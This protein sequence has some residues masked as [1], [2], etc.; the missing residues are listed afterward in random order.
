MIKR[1]NEQ[2]R[3]KKRFSVYS[4]VVSAVVFLI[5]G[6]LFWMQIVQGD[7]YLQKA[8]QQQLR[9]ITIKAPRGDILDRYGRPLVTNKTGY[10]LQIQ[11]TTLSN[12]EFNAVIL[13]LYD[14]LAEQGEKVLETLPVSQPPFAFTFGAGEPDAQKVSEQER[15]W[16]KANPLRYDETLSADEVMEKLR[17]RYKISADYTPEQMRRI[18]GV[19]YEMELRGFSVSTPFTIASDVSMNLV[20]KLKEE[21]AD[22]SCVNVMSEYVRQFDQGSLAAHI[23]GRVGIISGDE[24]DKYQHDGYKK[25]D[26][27][28]KQGIEKELEKYLRGKDGI[29]SMV[30][31]SEG[32]EMQPEAGEAPV[33]GDYVV[34]TIDSGLQDAVE[35]A[36]GQT[37]ENIRSR[38]GDPGAKSGG[39]AYCGAAVVLDVNSGAVLATATWPTYDPAKFREAYASMLSDPNKPMWNRALSGTYPPGSTFKMLTSIAA[40]EAGVI[41]PDTVIQDKGIYRFYSDYQPACWIWNKSHTTHGNQT[42]TAALV[43]SCNYFYYEVG[44]LMGIDTLNEYAKKFGF[45]EYTGIELSGEESQGRLAGPAD[46]QKY[47]GGQWRGGDTLQAAIG[48]SE[49]LFTPLQLANYVAT[50]ANG[51]TRY[52]PYLVKTVRAAGNG[53]C[54]LESTPEVIEEIQIKPETLNAIKSGML[55]VTENGTASSVFHNYPIKVGGKT[56][57]AQVSRGSDNGV[58]V[59]FAPFDKPEIAVAVVVEHGNSGSDVAPIA[60]AAFNQY[61][62]N[63]SQNSDINTGSAI[64]QLIH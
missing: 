62:L 56:G 19:R 49:N 32:F 43:N 20:T 55:G 13:R 3:D 24:Y 63:N 40:L 25:T 38:G 12:D 57:S 50:I 34:L 15:A 26:I 35:K 36:L 39:D 27:L 1:E 7:D 2:E 18:A 6:R 51:G 10:S 58:F 47:A 64:G 31:T 21:Q 8:Q 41:T 44:R 16:K 60:Q 11:K 53:K 30:Q 61:F 9:S 17:T 52:K 33:P 59:G 5:I 28:G 54:V 22:F 48:Q 29:S 42:V 46:R 14:M 4:A 23:L 45:G 37:I